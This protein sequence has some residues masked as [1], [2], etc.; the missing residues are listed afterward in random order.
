MKRA[1]LPASLKRFSELDVAPAL[2][3]GLND[4]F[5]GGI[6]DGL[7][8]SAVVGAALDGVAPDCCVTVAKR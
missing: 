7:G 5:I 1:R 4:A 3:C 6:L 2:V 8:A